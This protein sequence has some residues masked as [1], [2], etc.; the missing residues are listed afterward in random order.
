MG[1]QS[2]FP[3]PPFLGPTVNSPHR[4]NVFLW[5]WI[6]YHRTLTYRFL[7]LPLYFCTNVFLDTCVVIFST[8][9]KGRHKLAAYWTYLNVSPLLWI[10][11][12]RYFRLFMSLLGNHALVLTLFLKQTLWWHCYKTEMQLFGFSFCK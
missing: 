7:C 6:S 9:K 1:I 2:Q 4:A 8:E 11:L 5:E 10:L 3:Y 12:L